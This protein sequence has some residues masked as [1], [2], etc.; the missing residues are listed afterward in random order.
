MLNQGAELRVRYDNGMD[1]TLP[2]A[3]VQMMMAV[4]DDDAPPDA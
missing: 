3:E 1:G 4:A 2:L